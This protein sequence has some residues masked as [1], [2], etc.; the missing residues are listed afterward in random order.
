MRCVGNQ[1]VENQTDGCDSE[2]NSVAL[3]R[4]D[5][6][7]IELILTKEK[8]AVWADAVMLGSGDP[9]SKCLELP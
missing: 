6:D 8:L 4:V 7:D 9:G 5:V 3:V 2:K 1:D